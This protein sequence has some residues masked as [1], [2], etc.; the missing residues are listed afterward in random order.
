MNNRTFISVIAT[1]ALIAS[2]PAPASI[3]QFALIP[4]EPSQVS[5]IPTGLIGEARLGLAVQARTNWSLLLRTLT[6]GAGWSM[7]CSSSGLVHTAERSRQDTDIEE[8]MLTVTAPA[9]IPARYMIFGWQLL[10]EDACTDC[11]FAFKGQAVEDAATISVSSTGV[12]FEL[13]VPATVSEANS[14]GF[15]AC[16]PAPCDE[17]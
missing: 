11:V 16:K 8:L 6:V 4:L 10:A 2:L 7:Q 1:L 14:I 13:S 9:S 5:Q 15:Y 12:N 17:E 3:V